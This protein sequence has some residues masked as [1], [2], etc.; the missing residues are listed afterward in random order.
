MDCI[1]PRRVELERGIALANVFGGSFGMCVRICPERI[2]AV[3][4]Q[5]VEIRIRPNLFHDAPA[6][7]CVNRSLSRFAEDVPAGDFQTGKRANDGQV[8]SLG[9]A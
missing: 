6:Q 9:E 2:K 8:G 1:R 5:G 7:Q 3:M 4:G